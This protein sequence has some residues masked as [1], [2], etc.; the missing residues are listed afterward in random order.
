MGEERYE[1]PSRL[2]FWL[3]GTQTQPM[4]LLSALFLTTFDPS[5][6]LMVPSR[7]GQL[8]RRRILI[9]LCLHSTTALPPQDCRDHDPFALRKVYASL[10]AP[11]H[12]A[13]KPQ[14]RRIIPTRGTDPTVRGKEREVAK[15]SGKQAESSRSGHEREELLGRKRT[16]MKRYG[17]PTTTK[18]SN[19]STKLVR[20]R[21]ISSRHLT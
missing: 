19:N 2:F 3:V 17:R 8:E 15:K 4:M 18:Q 9:G 11:C 7:Q 5:W 20:E 21:S 14:K 13:Y 16:I 10:H 12:Q 1:V 6:S